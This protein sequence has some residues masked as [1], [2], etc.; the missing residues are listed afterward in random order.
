MAHIE[1]LLAVSQTSQQRRFI[2]QEMMPFRSIAVVSALAPMDS[3]LGTTGM[4]GSG[5]DLATLQSGLISSL[6]WK[7]QIKMLMAFRMSLLVETVTVKMMKWRMEMKTMT[8]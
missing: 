5:R 1:S 7:S 3:H 4:E 8:R 6:R 2:I